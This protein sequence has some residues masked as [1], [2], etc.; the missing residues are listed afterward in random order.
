[1]GKDP[2]D[3]DESPTPVIPPTDHRAMIV[4]SSNSGRTRETGRTVIPL[5]RTEEK[6]LA[7]VT[8]TTGNRDGSP[9]WLPVPF[10]LLSTLISTP[11]R[12]TIVIIGHSLQGRRIC[13]WLL[14]L[15]IPI[16][17]LSRLTRSGGRKGMG[18]FRRDRIWM[19]RGAIDTSLRV[20][21]RR[22]WGNAIDRRL[23]LR[24][25]LLWKT[26]EGK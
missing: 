22:I 14:L 2:I 16:R 9:P 26:H 11:R 20:R 19:G 24:L 4:N 15:R 18:S 17:S 21:I 1:M 7:T 10:H 23:L 12:P 8:G 13:L 3:P 5:R 25:H 6:G